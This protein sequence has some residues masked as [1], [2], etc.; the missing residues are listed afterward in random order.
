M[1]K[2][3]MPYL[4]LV[5]ALYVGAC[6]YLYFTQRTRLYEPTPQV[7]STHAEIISL[8][9]DGETLRIW[10]TGP[11]DGDA[12]IYFGGNAED[13]SEIIPDFTHAV[14]HASIYLVNYR[15]YGGSTGEPSEEGLFKDALAV[16]D[17][18]RA[19]YNHVSVVGRSLG[20]GVAIYVE[21]QREV[22]KLL[23]ITPYDSIENIARKHYPYFP[24]SLL[25]KDKFASDTRAASIAIPTM[26][27]L[28]DTD[29]VIPHEHTEALIAAFKKT[30]PQRRV[31]PMSTHNTILASDV[32]WRDVE[33]FLR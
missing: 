19:R 3:I 22:K 20:S 6:A 21:S 12:V 15:G 28:A 13:V 33:E 26:I 31:V 29:E 25:L 9:S 7:E 30:T 1:I 5:V 17:F 2:K 14:P 23:L 10:H 8:K 11:A 27:I 4:S 24:I 32:Y 18:V 16:Y